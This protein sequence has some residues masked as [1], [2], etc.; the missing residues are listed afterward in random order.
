[1]PE[2]G[3]HQLTRGMPEALEE[4]LGTRRGPGVHGGWHSPFTDDLKYF[5]RSN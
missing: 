2:I 5:M 3:R 4:T 1:M